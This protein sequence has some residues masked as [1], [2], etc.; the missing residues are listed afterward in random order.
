MP[1]AITQRGRNSCNSATSVEIVPVQARP[2]TT[3]TGNATAKLGT[4]TSS[5][6]AAAR[7]I[8]AMDKVALVH[9]NRRA[10]PSTSAPMIAPSPS[11]ANRMP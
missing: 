1:H 4:R 2:A 11:A 7:L 10:R 5:A 9:R 3:S 6:R 8:P